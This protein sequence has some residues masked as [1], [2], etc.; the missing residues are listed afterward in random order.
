MLDEAR[1]EID[2]LVSAVEQTKKHFGSSKTDW[3]MKE[4]NLVNNVKKM[5]EEVASLGKE[6]N[7]L[8]NLLK[9]TEEEADAAWKKEAQ[10]KDSLKEVE[11]EVVYLQETLGEAKAESMK[12]KES[13]MDKETE[14]QS[15][16]HENED[17]RAKEDVSVKKIEELSKLLEEAMLAKKKAEEE[18]VEL[19]ESE[20]DYDLLPK[21]VEFS[22]ENG[23]RSVEEKSPKVETIDHETPQEHISNGNGN[24]VE[25]KDVN[26]K[27]EAKVEKTE[28]KEE[29]PDDDKDDS[30]EVIFKMWES[31]QIEKKEAF[32]E[33]KSELESQ[34]E[35]EDSSKMDES[36][37]TSTENI[38]EIGNAL[39]SED[40]L[41][42]EKKIKK[43]KTLL[44]K[45]GNLLKKKAPAPVNQK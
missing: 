35:E 41:T 13:L 38:E 43:K 16:I 15:I 25:E 30:V 29:S 36:D 40:Q 32:P 45:V 27:P 8:D 21:V 33:K 23:H 9:R 34:E 18:D 5:E 12:L 14:F 22:S 19:S 4:A 39:T 37:K 7:R 31:C 2:V 3:E 42:M 26:G 20:K 17:L 28:K 11:E 10:T 6:M 44:G 1:H 24:G